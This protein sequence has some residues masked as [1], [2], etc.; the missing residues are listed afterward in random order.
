M[1]IIKKYNN[2]EKVIANKSVIDHNQLSNRDAYGSHSISAIR[3]LPEK[4]TNLKEKD[5]DL[6][7]QIDELDKG[8]LKQVYSNPEQFTGNGA[9]E[10][11]L[12]LKVVPDDLTLKI[13]ND[14]Y[15]VKA[16]E[17]SEGSYNAEDIHNDFD[18][19]TAEINEVKA[20]EAKH[21]EELT[22]KD[23][24]QD[25][26]LKKHKD[27]IYDLDARTRGMGGYL[28]A[29]DF[30][31]ATPSQE[32][33]TAYALQQIGITEESKIFNQTKVVN[34]N[35]NH[36]WVL[37]NTPDS[38]PAVFDWAD[39][40]IEVISD[41]NNDGLHGLVTGSYEELEGFIDINGHITI[42]KLE[43]KLVPASET[44][45]GRVKLWKDFDDNWNLSNKEEN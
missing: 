30:G 28:N 22:N 15:V 41:A 42:N 5:A 37:T 33:L 32:E 12:N 39:K 35:N 10:N 21:Y 26:E 25:S 43:E 7:K 14:K 44:E 20:D 18:D 40:G 17:D 8:S 34:L 6:Q 1:A 29:N 31:K 38:D 3:K 13:E 11:P 4:L 36:I 23:N 2:E 9:K 19:V 24:E 27:K 45:L 16:L